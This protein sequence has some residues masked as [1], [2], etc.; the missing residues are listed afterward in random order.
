MNTQA[1]YIT[2]VLVTC[3]L[4]LF[5]IIVPGG[6]LGFLG[7][8]TLVAASFT[9]FYAFGPEGG[10]ISTLLLLVALGAYAMIVVKVLPRS[11]FG[12]MFTLSKDLKN[13][14][15]STS[16]MAKFIGQTGSAITDLRPSGIAHINGQR[17]DV[18]AESNWVEKKCT[19]QSCAC[20]RQYRDSS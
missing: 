9:G 11:A 1:I 10:T 8:I 18:V 4:F 3:I 6:V 17:V 5:E 7:A 14:K 20:R 2:L 12:R 19:G 15:A 13:S 16:N